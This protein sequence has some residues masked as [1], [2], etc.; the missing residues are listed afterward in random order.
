[1]RKQDKGGEHLRAELPDRG[2]LP[3]QVTLALILVAYGLAPLL[4]AQVVT[5]PLNWRE[6]SLEQGLAMLK[7]S[8]LDVSVRRDQE[9]VGAVFCH[10]DGSFS[11]SYGSGRSGQDEVQFLVR[12]RSDRKVVGFWHTHGAHGPGRA[13]FSSV[14]ADLVRQTGLPFYLITPEGEI[15]VLQ[16]KHLREQRRAATAFFRRSARLSSGAHPGQ[17]VAGSPG[18][19]CGDVM[20]V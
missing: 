3:R 20:Q 4:N 15:R 11:F 19:S 10:L 12:G 9:Y 1:M 14:D 7:D 2:V 16:P 18:R 8:F 6:T 5:A 13:L 17:R